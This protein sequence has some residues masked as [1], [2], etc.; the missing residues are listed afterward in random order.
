MQEKYIDNKLA[1]RQYSRKRNPMRLE[2]SITHKKKQTWPDLVLFFSVFL[3]Y[4]KHYT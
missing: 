3:S 1:G 4:P 2:F